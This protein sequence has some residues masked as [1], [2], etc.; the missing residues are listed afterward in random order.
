MSFFPRKLHKLSVHVGTYLCIHAVY[1]LKLLGLISLKLEQRQGCVKLQA[2][3]QAKFRDQ[4]YTACEDWKC[5]TY[6]TSR[7]IGAPPHRHLWYR[8]N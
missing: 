1:A 3:I 6:L 4:S 2:P 8:S 7:V 5:Y